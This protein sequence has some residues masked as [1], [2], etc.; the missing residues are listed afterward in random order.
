MTLKLLSILSWEFRFEYY[1]AFR[2][3]SFVKINEKS[4]VINLL[5]IKGWRKLLSYVAH[6]YSWRLGAKTNVAIARVTYWVMVLQSDPRSGGWRYDLSRRLL[7]ALDCT[8]TM[9]LVAHSTY[10]LSRL[11]TA[12]F[13]TGLAALYRLVSV[14]STIVRL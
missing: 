1:I 4:V 13:V 8:C 11:V 3:C 6:Y 5:T 12:H 10:T 14:T 9:A 2:R 7:D